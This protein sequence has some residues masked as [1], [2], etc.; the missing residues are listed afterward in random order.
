MKDREDA[1]ALIGLLERMT[2][3]AIAQAQGQQGEEEEEEGEVGGPYGLF[4]VCASFTS[5]LPTSLP[6]FLLVSLVSSAKVFP[7]FNASF[8]LP[9]FLQIVVPLVRRKQK[10]KK[11]SPFPSTPTRVDVG[12][13][14]LGDRPAGWT[15]SQ[16]YVPGREGGRVG[17][18]EGEREGGSVGGRECGRE[19]GR[20]GGRERGRERGREGRELWPVCTPLA[21]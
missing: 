9:P 21:V 19:G 11:G 17:G 15:A 12:G 5:S 6:S 4:V 8:L 2:G 18:W 13:G 10:K 14:G 20:E 7:P 16:P 3:E 1:E